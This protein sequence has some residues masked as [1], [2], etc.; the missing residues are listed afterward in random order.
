MKPR[1]IVVMPDALVALDLTQTLEACVPDADVR[2]F[3][4]LDAAR[5][6]S[7][8]LARAPLIVV[9]LPAGRDDA[10]KVWDEAARL[11]DHLILLSDGG[12][13]MLGTDRRIVVLARPFTQEMITQA[14]LSF[15]AARC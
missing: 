12:Q 6:A 7:T 3:D 10:L 9:Q 14:V 15:C 2:T 8:G 5:L 11:G 1:L 13:S 4:S